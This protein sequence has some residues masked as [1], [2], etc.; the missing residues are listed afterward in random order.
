MNY[1]ENWEQY[2]KIKGIY[3]HKAFSSHTQIRR[4]IMNGFRSHNITLQMYTDIWLEDKRT[5]KRIK[6]LT[7]MLLLKPVETNIKCKIKSIHISKDTRGNLEIS[8]STSSSGSKFC[9]PGTL[10]PIP[11]E[12]FKY[13]WIKAGEGIDRMLQDFRLLTPCVIQKT[14]GDGIDFDNT[15]FP[16]L[17]ETGMELVPIPEGVDDYE[18]LEIPFVLDKYII[19]TPDTLRYLEA[20][21]KHRINLHE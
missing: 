8:S 15:I 10:K 17:K 2:K 7:E 11:E 18:L 14:V 12:V 4:V 6:S 16:V 19:K 20:Y 21:R 3:L 5:D 1:E 9:G 13:L